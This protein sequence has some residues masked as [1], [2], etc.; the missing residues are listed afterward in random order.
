MLEQKKKRL[1]DPNAETEGEEA[2]KIAAKED[3]VSGG[4]KQRLAIA[5]AFLKAPIILLLDETTSELDKDSGKLVQVSLDR[6]SEN[7]TSIANCSQ[8]KYYRRMC[9]NICIR[10]WKISRTRYPQTINNDELMNKNEIQK[11]KEI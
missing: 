3:P 1:L 10:K 11:K 8:I 9:S 4:E 5:R 6:L 2:Q 7:R